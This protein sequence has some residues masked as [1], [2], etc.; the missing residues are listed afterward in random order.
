MAKAEISVYKI[1]I[2]VR[3]QILTA[4]SFATG[5]SAGYLIV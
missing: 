1:E 3:H 5:L 4:Q 2:G